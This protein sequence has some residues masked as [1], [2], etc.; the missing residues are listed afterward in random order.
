M[1]QS[2][3]SHAG[4]TRCG[5]SVR[6]RRVSSQVWSLPPAFLLNFGWALLL[7]CCIGS[8]FA[9]GQQ[10]F[11][12]GRNNAART[13]SSTDELLLTP[14]NV[15][16]NSFGRLF[17]VPIDYQSLAQ[18]LYVPGV[19][20]PFQSTHNVVF[21]VTQANS[22]Y[23]YDADD[24]TL[25]WSTNLGTP[26]SG[27]YLPCGKLGGFTEEG[28]VGTPVIDTNT[29][30]LYL[31]AK[32]LVN[33][34]VGHYLHALDIATGNDRT[35]MGSPV[36]LSA[37]SISNKGHQTTF[38]SLHQKNRPGLLLLN[39][40]LYLAFG[41][42]GCND[43]NTGWILSYDA[44]T[45]QHLASFN[46]SPDIGLTSIWQ[47][48]NGVAGDEQG[49]IFVETAE[50]SNYDIPSGGQS[51]SNS[52]LKLSPNLE[53]TDFFTPSNVAFLN[54]ND[55]DMSSTGV[56]VLPDQDGN[57]VHEAIASGKQGTVY[58][59]DRDGLGMFST[60]ADNVVQELPFA[61]GAM[62]SSPAYWNNTVYFAGNAKPI[63]AFPLSG[64]LLGTPVQTAIRYT[65]AHSPSISANGNTNGILW[66]ISGGQ[67]RAF[68]AVSL[69]P[70]YTSVQAGTRDK[71]PA[72][73]HFATQTVVN[74]KVY[75]ATQNTLEVFG[76]FHQLAITAGNNQSALAGTALPAPIQV[77]AA[78]P[79]SGE[80]DE[81]V[82]VSFSDGGKGGTFNP[83]T[84]TTDSNGFVATVYTLPKKVGTYSLTISAATFANVIGTATAT[85]GGAV[86]LV[87]FAGAKQTGVAGSTLAKQIVAQAQDAFK[88][89]VAGV[90]V[91]FV[92]NPGGTLNPTSVITDA[93]GLA[94]TSLTLPTQ[95]ETVTVTASSPGLKSINFIEYSV[96]G[97]AASIA[98]ISGNNQTAPAGT[99]LP[100][101]LVVQVTDQYGNPVN[102]VS[103]DF[104]DGGNGG[105]FSNPN[106]GLTDATGKVSQFYTLPFTP[107]TIQ[108]TAS[109]A[110]VPTPAVFTETGTGQR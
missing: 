88:N 98:A 25:L 54:K 17:S 2:L 4:T 7:V 108:I 38:T 67:L 45:L 68:D 44:S 50:S 30:T 59:L 87:S 24:G 6:S 22:V 40:V 107:T 101:A 79:Y 56:L 9:F 76:L 70:I 39:G 57:H 90:T 5:V 35:S 18:P 72:L 32:A 19:Q 61:V 80:P 21:V 53:L 55:L 16:K 29:G 84:A 3:P 60:T 85:S 15:N 105:T 14:A 97:P 95:A 81:G 11:S 66:V 78:D 12:T 92:A 49:N 110:G 64:G 47:T 34:S 52:V 62:F 23:A 58:V 63:M 26:A 83:P 10:P 1:N 82:V 73:A 96:A 51:Y 103:V 89:P 102:A 77:Q 20:I 86:K 99:Q 106:P 91:N 31:V 37:T 36:Q 43:N 42:N 46:T 94:R 93:G 48:G 8:P 65:G 104:E 69:A 13:A 28:I 100:Q 74:G 75:I 27:Q 71:L 33:G 109:A 41:S